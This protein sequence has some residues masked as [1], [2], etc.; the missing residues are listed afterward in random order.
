MVPL[1]ISVMIDPISRL[2]PLLPA[3]AALVSRLP[4]PVKR[5]ATEPLAYVAALGMVGVT[6]LIWDSYRQR[7]L[8][9]EETEWL[10]SFRKT[11]PPEP[12]PSRLTLIKADRSRPKPAATNAPQD[13]GP[14]RPTDSLASDHTAANGP[15]ANSKHGTLNIEAEDGLCELFVDGLFVGNAP[16]RIKLGTGAHVVEIRKAG[17]EAYRREVTVLEDAELTMR[18]VWTNH[19]SASR[20]DDPKKV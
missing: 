4:E 3:Q 12:L 7:R 18:A 2:L 5:L 8:Q 9:R 11:A 19:N 10:A 16:A 6:F 13:G 15:K 17:Q 20:Q 1:F 14:M